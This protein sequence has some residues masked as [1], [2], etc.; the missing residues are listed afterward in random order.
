MFLIFSLDF[1]AHTRV[2]ENRFFDFEIDFLDKRWSQISF[3]ERNGE[4]IQFA[5]EWCIGNW[6]SSNI[7]DFRV[8]IARGGKIPKIEFCFKTLGIF[9][10]RTKF[11]QKV[12][13]CL[14]QFPYRVLSKNHD[15]FEILEMSSS[16]Y[17]L[18]L[19]ETHS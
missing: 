19:T 9:C 2:W 16:R 11:F 3:E 12:L 10:A 5:A 14:I 4:Y 18:I 7:C 6:S 15:D 8:N 17:F 1:S 13:L